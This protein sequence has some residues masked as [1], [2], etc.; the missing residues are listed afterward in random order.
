MLLSVRT[1]KAK[2]DLVLEAIKEYVKE[3]EEL[4]K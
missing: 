1:R 2:K 3:H 4:L